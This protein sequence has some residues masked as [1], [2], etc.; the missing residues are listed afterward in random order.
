M[1]GR[2]KVVA[3]SSVFHLAVLSGCA[4]LSSS[5]WI[6]TDDNPQLAQA[7]YRRGME[8]TQGQGVEQDYARGVA[9]FKRAAY[10]GSANG[11]YMTGMSY[12][13]GRG[14]GHSFSNA[15][16]WLDQAAKQGH[17]RAQYQLSRLYLG[18]NGVD[19]DPIWA[20]FLAGKAA[21]Q[22]HPKAA[23]ELAVG[24]AKG[25]GLPESDA[26]AWYWFSQAEKFQIEHSEQLRRK[27]QRLTTP[28]QRQ[29][30]SQRMLRRQKPDRATAQYIQ[31]QL[32]RIGYLQGS[33]DGIWGQQSRVAFNRYTR[34]ELLLSDVAIDW[35]T[36][37]LLRDTR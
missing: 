26:A 2:L 24:Y 21:A 25:L 35:N 29:Q 27:M 3:F 33:V 23:F 12:L 31:Q 8:Y 10:H 16:Q 37:Q 28:A 34:Q 17:S 19:R 32:K 30:I 20:M 18:G 5:G 7:E 11:A 22:N 13:T 14:V 9:E 4:E 1:S 15:A 36:L 6:A